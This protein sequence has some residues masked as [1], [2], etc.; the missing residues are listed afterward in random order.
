MPWQG[1]PRILLDRAVRRSGLDKLSLPCSIT[2]AFCLAHARLNFVGVFK[3][4]SS[5]FAKEF[6]ETIAAVHAIEKR[7]RGKSSELRDL[8]RFLVDH[9]MRENDL[10]VDGEGAEHMRGLAVGESVE[11]L[12][13]RLSVDGDEA[14]RCGGAGAVETFRMTTKRLLEFIGVE[15]LQ[16]PAHGGVGWRSS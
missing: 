8:V 1:R 16:D 2:L 3:T 9:F 5:P 11:A 15:P 13:Q 6:I 7:I 4:T 10:V 12:P 14:G